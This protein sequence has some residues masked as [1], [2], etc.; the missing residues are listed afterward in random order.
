MSL[1][2]QG[3]RSLVLWATDC[4]ERVLPCFEERYPKD[5]RPRQAV[6][7]GRAWVRGEIADRFTGEP[8]GHQNELCACGEVLRAVTRRA[9]RDRAARHSRRVAGVS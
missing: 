2:K 6:E 3:H 8:V 5:N 1:D 9:G 7:A 4:A